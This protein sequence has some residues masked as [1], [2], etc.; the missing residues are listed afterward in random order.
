[1]P[2]QFSMSQE[3]MDAK[4]RDLT[5][6][7]EKQQSVADELNE[8]PFQ[9]RAQ[10]AHKMADLN[11]QD[12]AANSSIPKLEFTFEKDLGGQEH[13]T[14]MASIKDPSAWIFKGKED[15]YNMPK[16]TEGWL[17]PT[18]TADTRDSDYLRN[19]DIYTSPYRTARR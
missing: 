18:L 5:D 11:A 10:I 4:A 2:E 13:L 14:D 1:M 19:P 9:E 6:K 12:R 8:I 17:T 16:A 3:Q 7:A 15:V